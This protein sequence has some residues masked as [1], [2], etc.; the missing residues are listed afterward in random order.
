MKTKEQL[1]QEK[2]QLEKKINL[3]V[4]K[5]EKLNKP[6]PIGFNYKNRSL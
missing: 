6:T 4:A 5:I 3:I 2:K 1:E